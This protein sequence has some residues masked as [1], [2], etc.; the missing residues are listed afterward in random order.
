[1]GSTSLREKLSKYREG[2]RYINS[3][4]IKLYEIVGN[5]DHDKEKAIELLI[6][7]EINTELYDLE[8]RKFRENLEFAAGIVKRTAA[9]AGEVIAVVAMP[10]NWRHLAG[11]GEKFGDSMEHIFGHY[12]D[13]RSKEKSALNMVGKLKS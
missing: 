1:M 11:L 10:W 9:F 8:K 6:A 2:T 3:K 7:S 13:H 4:L 12:K 5:V